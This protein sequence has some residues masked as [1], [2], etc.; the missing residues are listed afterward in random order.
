MN[1]EG[2]TWRIVLYRDYKYHPPEIKTLQEYRV[3]SWLQHA[4]DDYYGDLVGEFDTRE[5][6]EAVLKLLGD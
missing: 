3:C 6:A 4:V 5:E 1:Y 2:K